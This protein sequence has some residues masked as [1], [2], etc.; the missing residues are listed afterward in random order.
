MEVLEVT[1]VIARQRAYELFAEVLQRSRHELVSAVFLPY[2]DFDLIRSIHARFEKLNR[3][4]IGLKPQLV[5]ELFRFFEL[6]GDIRTKK[7]CIPYISPFG[8]WI[9]EATMKV[10]SRKKLASARQQLEKISGILNLPPPV[11][12]NHKRIMPAGGGK[13]EDD[14]QPAADILLMT[15][16]RFWQLKSL[17]FCTAIPQNVVMT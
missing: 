16:A 1:G 11:S 5:N 3:N 2:S 10:K 14:P 8:H 7:S 17:L 9:Q 12:R 4:E 13:R 15:V 6:V